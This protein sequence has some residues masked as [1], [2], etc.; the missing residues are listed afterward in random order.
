MGRKIIVGV[1]GPGEGANVE[2]TATAFELGKLIAGEGWV[3]LTGGRRAGVMEAASRG[4]RAGGGLTVG[5][6]SEVK[7]EHADAS[8]ERYMVDDYTN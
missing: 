1:I 3:L 6:N 2:A 5:N 8:D 7:P 4:A